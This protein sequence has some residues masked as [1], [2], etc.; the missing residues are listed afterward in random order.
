MSRNQE[1]RHAYYDHDLGIEAY[2]LSGVVQK[3]PNHFHN[4][5][6]I[7][8]MEG[9]QR[10]LWC[11]G[12]EYDLASGDLV[13]FNP[14]DNHYCLPIGGEPLDYRAVNISPE[15]MGN[16][17]R[18]ITGQDYVPRFTQNVV[19]QSAAALSV[20]EL[21]DGILA[22]APRLHKEEAFFYLL[23]QILR[24]YAPPQER[25]DPPEPDEQIKRL[26]AYM[27]QHYEENISL[28]T[29]LSMTTIGKSYLLRLF[30]KQLGVSPYRYLQTIRIDQ[31]KKLLEQGVEPIDAAHRTG[32]SDQS[33]FTNFFKS[34]IGLTPK[35][36]QRIFTH[37]T[38]PEAPGEEARVHER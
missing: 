4:F 2:Q 24:E 15:V 14:R 28:E 33:H 37:G 21:Y 7:G 26:C 29:L 34:F 22:D 27:E 30:T 1:Q 36:Y 38:S 16:A 6:V 31:A 12:R 10:H 9:G 11:K 35:Q 13:L 8:F 5:Y 19:Y 25:H 3:F 23:E 20:G 32:F 18:E 17:A